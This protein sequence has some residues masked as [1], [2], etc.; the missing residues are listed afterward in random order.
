MI[1]PLLYFF[2]YVF[3][4]QRELFLLVTDQGFLN[5]NN[6]IW[7]TLSNVEGDC[8]F[9]DADFK[10]YRKVEPISMPHP[11]PHRSM[12]E[13]SEALPGSANQIDQE[14]VFTFV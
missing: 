3:I 10:T 13:D 6:V 11:A 12:M 2:L 14:Y 7:E 1:L 5:E 9:V 4:F 8:H